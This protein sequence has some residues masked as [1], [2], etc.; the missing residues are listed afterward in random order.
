MHL[1]SFLK[2]QIWILLLK[3]LCRRNPAVL[4][5]LVSVQTGFMYRKRF[6]RSSV[7]GWLSRSKNSGVAQAFR[8][9]QRRVHRLIELPF[10]RLR[11]ILRVPSARE[12]GHERALLFPQ[13]LI[14]GSFFNLLY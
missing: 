11:R 6:P 7:G 8:K 13:G 4:V 10:K 2:M 5:R 1:L 14:R 9:S 12:P 3:V